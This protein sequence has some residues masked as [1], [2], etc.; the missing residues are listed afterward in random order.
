MSETHNILV[1][2]RIRDVAELLLIR[3]LILE[4]VF[5]VFLPVFAKRSFATVSQIWHRSFLEN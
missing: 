5:V 4:L 1:A 3:G 2:D